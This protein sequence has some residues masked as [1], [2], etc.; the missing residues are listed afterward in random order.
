MARRR[1]PTYRNISPP[2]QQT[3][4]R[5]RRTASAEAAELCSVYPVLMSAKHD[6]ADYYD[7][8]NTYNVFKVSDLTG[9]FGDYASDG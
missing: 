8:S 1:E 2:S 4:A 7:P 6:M 9:F 3:S 5:I